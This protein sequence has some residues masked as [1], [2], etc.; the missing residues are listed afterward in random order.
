MRAVARKPCTMMR[1]VAQCAATV[2][3]CAAAM[4]VAAH[5]SA[6][7]APGHAR[8]D[9]AG[10]LQLAVEAQRIFDGAAGLETSEPSRARAGFAESATIYRR[11][12]ESGVR[13]G[14][15]MLNL[16]NALVKSGEPSR[17]LAAYLDAER[18]LPGDPRVQ[19]A[20][21]H[22]RSLTASRLGPA[23]GTTALDRVASWWAPVPLQARAWVTLAAWMALWGVV[24][25]GIVTGWARGMP[26]KGALAALAVV[27]AL[28]AVTVGTDMV[29][30]SLDPP[31]VLVSEGVVLRKGNGE[32]F[33]PAVAE[34]LPSGVE[35]TM[36]EERPGWLRIRLPDGQTGWVRASDAVV[37]SG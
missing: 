30:T 17:A 20:L 28:P 25:V 27:A 34:T 33:A 32:G 7:G 31:G 35:F 8:L 3:A 11:I 16:G 21:A 14:E 4:G 37:C 5:A 10:R 36:L 9:A 6:D 12:A 2:I 1:A 24:A 29:R 26:W 22:A 15:L 18:L 23:S 13:N 19:D